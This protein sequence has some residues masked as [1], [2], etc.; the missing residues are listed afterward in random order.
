[1][2]A[3]LRTAALNRILGGV[4]AAAKYNNL[5]DR[6]QQHFIDAFWLGN[7]FVEYIHPQRGPIAS[8]GLTDTD[9]SALAFG[10]LTDA[11]GAALWPQLRNET[12][13]Y[14]GGIPTGIATEPEK[15]QDWEFTYPDQQALAAMGRVWYVEARARARM[16]DADGLVESIRRVCRAGRDGGWYWRERYG[17]KG[18]FGAQKYCEYPANLIRIVQRFLLGFE[19]GLDGTVLLA[20]I[21]PADFWKKGFGQSMAWRDRRLE[22]RFEMDRVVGSY[23]GP[24]PQRVVIRARGRKHELTLRASRGRPFH[25]RL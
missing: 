15:Y 20:P 10:T 5:A 9:W 1:V 17:P 12:R 18:G 2:D 14:Y 11:Q 13:F 8:H 19:L 25:A 4:A 6:I 7:R 21:A 23:T 16:G 3:L 24:S 22:Y